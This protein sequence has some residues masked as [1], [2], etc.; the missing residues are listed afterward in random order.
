MVAEGSQNGIQALSFVVM[1]NCSTLLP[2][3]YDSVQRKFIESHNQKYNFIHKIPGNKE[4]HIGMSKHA[5]VICNFL[6]REDKLS[7]DCAHES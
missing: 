3:I 4:N 1:D 7:H 5:C 6:R 2:L